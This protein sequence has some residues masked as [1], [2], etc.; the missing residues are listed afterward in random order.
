MASILG[1]KPCIDETCEDYHIYGPSDNLESKNVTSQAGKAELPRAHC[2]LLRPSAVNLF[3][4]IETMYPGISDIKYRM[5][6][7]L[8]EYMHQFS[9][10]KLQSCESNMQLI[11]LI[12]LAANSLKTQYA[13]QG[14]TECVYETS[15]EGIEHIPTDRV[16]EMPC[17]QESSSYVTGTSRVCA[18][19]TMKPKVETPATT[20][21]EPSST[22]WIT[23]K[24]YVPTPTERPSADNP[25]KTPCLDGYSTEKPCQIDAVTEEYSSAEEIEI[26]A[27]DDD[28]EQFPQVGSLRGI[29]GVH[30]PNYTDIPITSFSC[31]D[32]KYIPGFYAD[33]DTGCQVRK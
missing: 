1:F 32:K 29:P 14:D 7:D 22:E 24:P 26:I 21:Y 9:S 19:S 17:D 3:G 16:S 18:G 27:E 5:L 4:E 33:L 8:I 20:L 10:L 13:L 2:M 6:E 31:A 15:E 30:Y 28:S 11:D 23:E 12:L 25:S